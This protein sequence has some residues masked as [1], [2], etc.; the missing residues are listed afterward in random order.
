MIFF[1]QERPQEAKRRNTQFSLAPPR[2]KLVTLSY[3]A[4]YLFSSIHLQHSQHLY[5]TRPDAC[6]NPAKPRVP[7]SSYGSRKGG[8]RASLP[9]QR[10]VLPFE[11]DLD[12]QV[13]PSKTSEELA[14]ELIDRAS[15]ALESALAEIDRPVAPEAPAAPSAFT[16]PLDGPQRAEAP[17][18]AARSASPGGGRKSFFS[19]P[20]SRPGAPSSDP[21]PP[22][23]ASS[24]F[25][26]G[27]GGGGPA[28][29]APR[30][31]SSPGV[32]PAMRAPSAVLT[33]P[34]EL[35]L[36][37]ESQGGARMGG[38]P[39]FQ[40]VYDLTKAALP[41]VMGAG[42]G[43]APVETDAVAS[44]ETAPP[45]SA[46]PMPFPACAMRPL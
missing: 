40:S 15:R 2:L 43:P 5:L 21:A 14:Q 44:A 27:G 20:E 42:M 4:P 7:F 6:A 16:S 38:L 33:K 3:F 18:R 10:P 22:P 25:G 30:M 11:S 29:S 17:S 45:P 26:G 36:G 28:P 32:A 34:R 23:P 9:F 24:S 19:R 39:L 41:P 31:Q 46:F 35:D 37:L 12:P 8:R 1:R 13:R